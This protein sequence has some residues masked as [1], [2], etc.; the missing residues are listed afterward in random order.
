[1]N[2]KITYIVEKLKSA[3]RLE[4][5]FLL[6]AGFLSFI[7]VVLLSLL[8]ATMVETLMQ[9]GITFR[10]TLFILLILS[11]AGAFYH[12]LLPYLLRIMGI[13][14]LPDIEQI[15]ARVGRLY[16]EIKD[17]LL[18]ALQLVKQDDSMINTSRELSFAYFEDVYD[19]SSG[20]DFTKIVERKKVKKSFYFVLASSLLTIVFLLILSSSLTASFE[21]ILNFRKE[22]L[23]S[24]PFSLSIEPLKLKVKRG[25]TV[26]IH[27]FVKGVPPQAVELNIKEARQVNFDKINL[28][29]LDSANVFSYKINSIKNSL[30]F[31]AQSPWYNKQIKTKIGKIQVIDRPLIRSIAGKLMPPRYTN[32]AAEEFNEEN[33][34]LTALKGTKVKFNLLTSSKLKTAKMIFITAKNSIA[35][36]INLSQDTLTI[37]LEISGNI[38]KGSFTI[39]RNGKYYFKIYD[40]NGIDN[41]AP[42][43]YDVVALNDEYPGIELIQPTLDVQVDEEALLATMVNISDDYGFS[44][45]Y[46]NYKLIK[47]KY[48]EPDTKFSKIKIPISNYNLSMQVPYLWDLKNLDITPED[49]YE[50]YFEVLDNDIVGGAKSAETRHLKVRLPSLDEVLQSADESQKDLEK[51][52]KELLNKTREIKQ[53]MEQMNREL[54][55]KP[56]GTKLNWKEKKQAEDILKKQADLQ[57]QIDDLQNEMSSMTQKLQQNNAISPETLQKYKELQK[58]LK[59]VSSSELQKLQQQFE[60]AINKMDPDLLR[61]MMENT[62]FNEEQFRKSIERTIKL[63]KRLKAEQK[64]DALQKR[65]DELL[66]KQ[67]NLNKETENTNST[68]KDKLNKLSKE[69][70]NLNDEVKKIND[71]LADL[72]KMMKELGK[73]M[74]MDAMEQAKQ[75]LN[76]DETSA[77]MQNASA[78]LSKANMN[79][80]SSSQKKATKNLKKFSKS[81]KNLKKK[82]QNE[83]TKQ[84]IRKM[85]KAIDD[86][87]E[88]SK[89]QEAIK[90]RTSNMDY[91]STKMSELQDKEGDI[92]QG[93]KNV[94][95]AMMEL[96]QKS[97]A[98][99]PEMGYNLGEAMQEMQKTQASL[100][101]RALSSAIVHQ[102]QAMSSINKAAMEMQSMLSQMKKSGSGSCDNPGGEGQGQGGSGMSFSQRLRQTAQQQQGINNGMQQMMGQQMLNGKLS[103]QQQ[104]ELG[105]IAA[106]QG[107]ARKTL[108]ELATEQKKF[109]GNKKALGDLNKIVKEMDE[110]ISDM[111]SGNITPETLNKQ[112][113]ILSR[114]LDAS[115]SMNERDF[116]KKRESES[117]NQFNRKSPGPIPLNDINA[118]RKAVEDMNKSLEQDYT[119]DY[120]QLIKRYFETIQN[121]DINLNNK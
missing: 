89:Q 96:S 102:R 14:F 36:T 95:N 109:G 49:V 52:A 68:N 75:D 57:K 35:D 76:V 37:P 29:N 97:L 88:L 24:A 120:R 51:E 110:V 116:E 93:L 32:L 108:D 98:V 91:G 55:K 81:M 73:D 26:E 25:E 2:D 50:F 82:M 21:R 112:E 64:T 10:T 62:K 86:L 104:A 74:P 85:Q 78:E 15:A 23:P 121:S 100:S 59:E 53:D 72:E 40:M 66:R 99:T 118:R 115:V 63:L 106:K 16:P 34:D 107:S 6:F 94:A 70:S 41:E 11:V 20:K 84:A 117:G 12:Y 79:N 103:Q 45:L 7:S 54:M 44:G 8:V 67:E 4:T 61:N 22:Y 92:E 90:Q 5:L 69:Q 71:E 83:V 28:T 30:Q 105:R 3:R 47:S 60:N 18:N 13:K 27:V 119:R 1:M 113:R 58:L 17:K 9:G 56:K 33:A 87:V 43:V 65:A 48:T 19:V 31:F 101:N 111:K 114:L 38:A 77:E 39:N 42:I 46:L 80:A